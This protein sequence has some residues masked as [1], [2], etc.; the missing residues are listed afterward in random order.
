MKV[1]V[2]VNLNLNAR[3]KQ[4]LM[5]GKNIQIGPEHLNSNGDEFETDIKNVNKIHI[6]SCQ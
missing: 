2:K 3:Q 5:S 6:K 4:A 1:K